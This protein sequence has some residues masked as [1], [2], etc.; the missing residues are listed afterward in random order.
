[1]TMTD[2]GVDA[3]EPGAARAMVEELAEA[4]VLD[5]VVRQDEAGEVALSGE[6]GFLP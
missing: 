4:G 5:R 2:D 3:G 6:G 1:M